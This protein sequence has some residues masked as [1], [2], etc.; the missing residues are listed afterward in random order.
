MCVLVGFEAFSVSLCELLFLVLGG[1][2]EGFEGFGD[3][4]FVCWGFWVEKDVIFEQRIGV[5]HTP[6]P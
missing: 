1:F 6:I 3:L 2:L 5:S 4:G